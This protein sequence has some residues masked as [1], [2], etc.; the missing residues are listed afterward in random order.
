VTA[1]RKRDRIRK[2][3]ELLA[4]HRAATGRPNEPSKQLAAIEALRGAVALDH[5]DRHLLH[6]LVRGEPV[7]AVRALAAAAHG[8]ARVGQT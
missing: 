5:V 6:P 4:S 8:V 7:A 3:F 1:D 2:L